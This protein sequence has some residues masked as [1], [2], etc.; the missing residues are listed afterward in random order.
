MRHYTAS[1]REKHKF[2]V[3]NCKREGI[4]L[5]T[6]KVLKKCINAERNFPRA[7]LVRVPQVLISGC[8]QVKR[9]IKQ[10]LFFRAEITRVIPIL[11]G[12]EHW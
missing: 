11:W 1:G 4:T 2:L 10:D 3:I 9:F 8:V 7:Y 12:H 5:I 6:I